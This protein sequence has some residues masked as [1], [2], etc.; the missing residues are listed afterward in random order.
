[1]DYIKHYNLLIEKA[2]NRK[3]ISLYESHHIIPKSL[4]GIDDECNRVNLTLREHFVAHMLLAKI[5]GGGMWFA[6]HMMGNRGCFK[7][8]RMY[9]K[10]KEMARLIA[11]EKFKGKKRSAESIEKQKNTIKTQFNK[12]RVS[13]RK[14]S[15]ISKS[16]KDSIAKANT[17]KHIPIKSRSSLEGYI[18]R[19]GKTDGLI[20]YKEDSSKKAITLEKF[21]KLYGDV[22]GNEKWNE[23]N[24]KKS[25]KFSGKRNP[26][27]GKKHTNESLEKMKQ[28]AKNREKLICKNCG[29]KLTKAMHNRWHGDN[30]KNSR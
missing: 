2:K 15:K 16:H 9:K 29:K 13:H 6:L 22:I 1:M 17:G 24:N 14:G 4:G 25:L 27:H 11:K 30:C 20:K 12:G 10:A 26:F 23:L 7:N 28:K 18:M 19:Y 3:N 8:S 21:I 5:Y